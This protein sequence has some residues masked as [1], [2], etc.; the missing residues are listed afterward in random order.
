MQLALSV[1]L[2]KIGEFVRRGLPVILLN[3]PMKT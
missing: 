3:K 2:L 1:L